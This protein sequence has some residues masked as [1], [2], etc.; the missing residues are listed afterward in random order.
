[1]LRLPGEAA[2]REGAGVGQVWLALM[3]ARHRLLGVASWG[4]RH[5]R[6]RQRRRRRRCSTAAAHLRELEPPPGRRLAGRPAGGAGGRRTAGPW[7][8]VR[9]AARRGPGL[10]VCRSSGLMGAPGRSAKRGECVQGA[11]EQLLRASSS[12]T[13]AT[14]V[15]NL[16]VSRLKPVFARSPLLLVAPCP[17]SAPRSASPAACRAQTHAGHTPQRADEPRMLAHGPPTR[18]G[19]LMPL[20][21][22]AAPPPEPALG[23][24][25]TARAFGS[26]PSRGAETGAGRC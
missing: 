8:R 25:P 16:G 1:M 3:S 20:L 10:R 7:G 9:A 15:L 24:K 12:A 13:C 19:A 17:C 5:R 18:M 11:D 23:G 2:A 21:A 4:R 26:G 14:Q 22:P 6:R